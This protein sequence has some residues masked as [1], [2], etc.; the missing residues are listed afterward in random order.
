MPKKPNTYK[1]KPN[2][3]NATGRPTDYKPEY[4]QMM[5]D[6]FDVGGTEIPER[7]PT[8]TGFAA[9]IGKT[10]K[11]IR[12]WRK[13]N[14]EFLTTFMRCKDRQREVWLQNALT[15]KYNPQFAKFVGI[16]VIGWS[17]KKELEH[18]GKDGEKL[19]ID[20]SFVTADESSS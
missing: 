6:F 15:N 11:T 10:R 3:K 18:T 1:K 16:N 20:I 8:F 14:P 12:D 13:D 19:S 4:C 17:D 5:L 2:G 7:L 9:T